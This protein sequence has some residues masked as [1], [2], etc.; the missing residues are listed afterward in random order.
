MKG[1]EGFG[2]ILTEEEK[3][4]LL[5]LEQNKI[6]DDYFFL[7]NFFYAGEYVLK[8]EHIKYLLIDFP[9]NAKDASYQKLY[10][11]FVQIFPKLDIWSIY[12]IASGMQA[13][14]L[15]SALIFDC[16]YPF[17]ND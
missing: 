17:Q 12:K 4:H 11:I 7:T 8:K 14:A 5:L 1:Y 3:M 15:P 9:R 2:A 13:F 16:K 6:F 10:K